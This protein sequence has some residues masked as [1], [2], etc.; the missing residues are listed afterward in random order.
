MATILRMRCHDCL[1]SI[2]T[3]VLAASI[4]M[5]G[6]TSQ[7]VVVND[8]NGPFDGIQLGQFFPSVARLDFAGGRCSGSLISPT[9][10]LTAEHCF[11]N[12]DG[13][14]RLG[15]VNV[16]FTATNTGTTTTP[17][18]MRTAPAPLTFGNPSFSNNPDFLLNGDDIALLTL[19]QPVTQLPSLRLFD[20]DVVGEAGFIVGFGRNGV[21]STGAVGL[22]GVRRAGVNVIDDLGTAK[23]ADFQANPNNPVLSDFPNTDNILSADFDA[24]NTNTLLQLSDAA[25]LVG[26]GFGAPGDSGGPLLILRDDEL[27]IAGVLSGLLSYGATQATYGDINYW[28]SVSDAQIRSFIEVEG[29]GVFL[30]ADTPV[31]VPLP[32]SAF[33]LLGGLGALGLVRRYG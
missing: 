18:I 33:L 8:F 30:P 2:R 27:L 21:G 16:T 1:A 26:E 29:S 32:A 7:A 31:L 22:D 28:T 19:N 24:G 17:E 11:R 6:S 14:P 9:T 25:P 5:I 4:A 15:Q 23:F 20:G 3:A 13:T 12:D 10:V